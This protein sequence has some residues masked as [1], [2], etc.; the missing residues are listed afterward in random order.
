MQAPLRPPLSLLLPKLLT[1][2][3]LPPWPAMEM[4]PWLALRTHQGQDYRPPL[5]GLA[6]LAPPLQPPHNRG[7]PANNNEA[8]TLSHFWYGMLRASQK[9]RQSC[10]RHGH[11]LHSLML[12]CF[13]KPRLLLSCAGSFR[14]MQSTLSQH[15]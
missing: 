4:L 3:L 14:T 8:S 1:L 9:S 12:L 2:L 6:P 11:T 10:M 5:Q 7:L 13:Q 15:P